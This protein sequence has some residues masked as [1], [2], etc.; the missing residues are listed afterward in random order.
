MLGPPRFAGFFWDT[1]F[2]SDQNSDA[3][4]IH[5]V[6]SQYDRSIPGD[7]ILVRFTTTDGTFYTDI[8]LY[9][10]APRDCPYYVSNKSMF[11]FTTNFDCMKDI[12]SKCISWELYLLRCSGLFNSLG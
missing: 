4:L 7:D 11:N 12:T 8:P 6:F 2:I 10:G 3:S 5:L 1:V 9:S